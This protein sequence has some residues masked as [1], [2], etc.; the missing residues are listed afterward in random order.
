MGRCYRRAEACLLD[1]GHLVIVAAGMRTPVDLLPI[2][3]EMALLLGSLFDRRRLLDW[4][5]VAGCAWWAVVHLDGRW[6]GRLGWKAN[7]ER[8]RLMGDE[9]GI[10]WLQGGGRAD[11][12]GEGVV[13]ELRMK[14]VCCRCWLRLLICCRREWTEEIADQAVMGSAAMVVRTKMGKMED[15]GIGFSVLSST[16]WV[17]WIGPPDVQ[18]ELAAGSHGCRPW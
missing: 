9:G 17:A 16:F 7:G 3:D 1:L 5:L 6:D 8:W 12:H 11:G 4:A 18:L 14:E 13:G 15:G 10:G 2:M